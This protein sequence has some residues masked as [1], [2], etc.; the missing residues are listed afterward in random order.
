[1]NTIQG[2][3]PGTGIA[4]TAKDQSP[5]ELL[6]ENPDRVECGDGAAAV[7]FQK[8]NR[9]LLGGFCGKKP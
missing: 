7:Q 2:Q 8:F 3:M 5:I 4:G 6:P 1:M 9:L